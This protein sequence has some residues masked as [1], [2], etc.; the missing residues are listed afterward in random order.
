M[1]EIKEAVSKSYE[2]LKNM[3]LVP[4]SAGIELEE[5]ELAEDGTIWVVTLSYPDP[6]KDPVLGDLG[7]NLRSILSNRRAYK[8][9]R[10]QASDGSI[11]GIKSIHA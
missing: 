10:V 6:I 9:V 3:S 4:E 5:A 11:R 2:A 8:A 1:I 7:P